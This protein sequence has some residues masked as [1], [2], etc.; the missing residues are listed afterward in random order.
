MKYTVVMEH[1]VRSC[2]TVDADSIEEAKDAAYEQSFREDS[3]WEEIDTDY[4][5]VV[6]VPQ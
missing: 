1:K 4:V 6:M 2:Q 5:D 3:C